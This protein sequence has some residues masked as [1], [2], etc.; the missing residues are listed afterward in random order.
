MYN[1][2]HDSKYDSDLYFI[3]EQLKKLTEQDADLSEIKKVLDQIQF[4]DQGQMIVE[5]ADKATTAETADSALTAQVADSANKLTDAF[6]LNLVG[7]VTGTA[8]VDGSSAVNIHTTI[9]GSTPQDITTIPNDLTIQ[10]NLS[11]DNINLT[12]GS[13]LT[14]DVVGNATSSN[15]ATVADSASVAESA[16]KLGNE[17]VG[18]VRSPIYLDNGVATP[19]NASLTAIYSG[20]G[21]PSAELGQVGDIFIQY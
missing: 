15:R 1:Y 10:G 2:P 4:N 11:V 8:S 6:L 7:D 20:T 5:M 17:S 9:Q 3:I 13:K 12:T 18:D 21:E 14:G 19:C 16:N